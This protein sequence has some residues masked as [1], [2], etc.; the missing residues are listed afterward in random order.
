[1]R[2]KQIINGLLAAAVLTSPMAMADQKYPAADFQPEVV[3]QDKEYIAND[4]S[5]SVATQNSSGSADAKY[6]AANFEPQVI[7]ND[8][9]YKHSESL[10]SSTSVQPAVAPSSGEAVGEVSSPEKKESSSSN[11]LIILAAAA[12]GALLLFRKK[13]TGTHKSSA[14]A[15]EYATASDAQKLTGVARYL[16]KV[17]GTGVSRYIE[18]Q[19]KTSVAA[20]GVARYVA[21]QVTTSKN[22]STKQAV[23]GVEKYMRNRG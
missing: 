18:K 16:N 13:L 3:F 8:T 22:T 9:D 15:T 5:S 21:K 2:K 6:P 23:T 14:Q 12:I 17:S 20:T 10:K 11:M 7:Y 19:V 4:S 1:M